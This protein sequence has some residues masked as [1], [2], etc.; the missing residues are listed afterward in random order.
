MTG[1]RAGLLIGLAGVLAYA[2]GADPVVQWEPARGIPGPRAGQVVGLVGGE[3][4]AAGGTCGTEGKREASGDLYIYDPGAGMWTLGPSL[5]YPIADAAGAALGDRLYI[6]SGGDGTR[7]Y[8]DT[9]ICLRYGKGYEYVR[10][11][12]LPAPRVRATAVTVGTRVFVVGGAPDC[13]G[14]GKL[15][16]DALVYDL[17]RP[18]D[19]WRATRRMPGGGIAAAAVTAVGESIYVFGGCTRWGDARHGTAA[20]FV[21]DTVKDR[22]H[23]LPEC[24]YAAYG[25]RAVTLGRVVYLMGGQ[26]SW[27]AMQGGAEGVAD[28]ILRFD[29][30]KG[31]YV[32]VGKLSGAVTDLGVVVLGAG[33][34]LVWGGT[35]ASGRST[36]ACAVG[37]LP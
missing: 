36:D 20:A 35:D 30:D 21:Y 28:S 9:V 19:G 16:N 15:Y 7:A 24:P 5:P 1:S 37:T 23:R 33:R 25:W 29:P 4:L 26:A 17:A 2:A 31:T 18:K 10:G 12:I 11:P 6:L 27:P 13:K 22:W 3:V 32:E 34:L 8:R 14:E